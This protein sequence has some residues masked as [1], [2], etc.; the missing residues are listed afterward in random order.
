MEVLNL[1]NMIIRKPFLLVLS[2]VVIVLFL[3]QFLYPF[4]DYREIFADSELDNIGPETVV[5]DAGHGG[6]DGGAVSVSGAIESQINLSIA[7][8]LDLIMGLYGI[9]TLMLR[10]SDISLHSSDAQTIREKKV[11]D[12]HNRVKIIESLDDP[13]VI[14]IHQNTYSDKRYHGAQVFYA[15]GNLSLP[16]ADIVQKYLRESLD[17]DNTRKPTPVPKSVYLM[18]HITC[19]AILVECG[20]LSNPQE[21]VLLQTSEYQRKLAVVLACAYMQHKQITQEGESVN[22]S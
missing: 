11:S 5:I 14:S 12:L 20:F 10:D 15:N 21:D 6:E 13:T 16:F 18:K 8:R 7:Q 17:P 3:V 22:A 9:K 4:N 19:K 2:A 1:K